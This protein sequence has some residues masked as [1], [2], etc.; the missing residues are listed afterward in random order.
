M[1]TEADVDQFLNDLDTDEVTKLIDLVSDLNPLAKDD[2]D[3]PVFGADE[4]NLI[5]RFQQFVKDYPVVDAV[6]SDGDGVED[7]DV[8]GENTDEDGD[9]PGTGEDPNPDDVSV[10]V[11]HDYTFIQ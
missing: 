6:D 4:M 5:Q 9:I 1:R 2:N 8:E 10:P 7:E 3:K 11:K